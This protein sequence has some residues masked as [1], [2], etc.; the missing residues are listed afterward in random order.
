[1][2]T[3]ATIRIPSGEV[4]A[5][6]AALEED[7]AAEEEILFGAIEDDVSWGVTDFKLVAAH[8]QGLAVVEGQERS[9]AGIDVHTEESSGV[10]CTWGPRK[11]FRHASGKTAS[12]T[13][14]RH[15]ALGGWGNLPWHTTGSSQ[16]CSQ[17]GNG[18]PKSFCQ[19]A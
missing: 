16:N 13:P 5:A 7:I 12:C 4:G 18:S 15:T 8:V 10:H 1:M 9:R 11:D 17:T 3:P 6:E 14:P 19:G 2:K